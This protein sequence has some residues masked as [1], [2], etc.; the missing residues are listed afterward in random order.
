MVGGTLMEKEDLQKY[1]VEYSNF[2]TNSA[3]NTALTTTTALSGTTEARIKSMLQDVSTNANN[4]IGLSRTVKNVNG[5]YKRIIKYM[6]SMLTYDHLIYPVLENPYGDFDGEAVKMSFAQTAKYVDTLNP[7]YHLPIFTEK[8]LTN[9]TAFMYKIEDSKSV[10]YQDIPYSYCKISYSEDGVFR[11]EIDISKLSDTTSLV[12]P[13]EILSAY[14]SYK[15]G[16]RDKFRDNKWYQVSDKG[17]AFTTDVDVLNQLG[18][19]LP[20]FANVLVDALKIENAKEGM[21]DQN[22]LDNSKIIHSQVPIDDKGRPLMELNVVKAYHNSLKKNLP[23]GSVAVTNPFDTK[24]LTLN[25]TGKSEIFSLLDKSTEQLYRSAGISSQLFA[26]DNA[27]SQALERSIQVDEQWLYSFVLPM[28]TNYYNY[29][30]KKAS[31]KGTQWRIKFVEVSYFD[32]DEAVKIAKDQL[33]YGGSRQEYLAY[34]GMTPSQVAN[35]L[36][37]EQEI[38]D[39]DKYMVAKQNSNTLSGDDVEEAGRPKEDNPTDTTTR[40]NDSQ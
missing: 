24:A 14:T 37:F 31:K 23:K 29:E 32:R 39:I 27:S 10:A 9:G 11:F 36:V 22:D 1:S 12:M 26:D 20:A 34:S 4:I 6:S 13:K 28:Y 17:V 19:A 7:K 40:I 16:Q 35:M 3:Y 30:L 25:G 33:T 8:M 21:E 38:L 15:N 5:M 18:Y 2:A